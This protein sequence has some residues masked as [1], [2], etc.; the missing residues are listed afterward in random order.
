MVPSAWLDSTA[1]L[2]VR[3]VAPGENP[4]AFTDWS[5]PSLSAMVADLRLVA[6]MAEPEELAARLLTAED[7]VLTRGETPVVRARAQRMALVMEGSE[8]YRH[9]ALL[10]VQLQ[11]V[12]NAPVWSGLPWG[13]VQ[14]QQLL[15]LWF[16][17]SGADPLSRDSSDA[18][19]S[20]LPGAWT[21]L[22][23]GLQRGAR[24]V[25]YPD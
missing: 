9:D 16:L 5:L 2:H 10:G 20:R 1:H 15:Y 25:P 11:S 19:L 23:E 17:R 24:D 12:V 14:P 7:F 13:R 3:L 22:D 21:A 18:A 6:S 4:D 8:F